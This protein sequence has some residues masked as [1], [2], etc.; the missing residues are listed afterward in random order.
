MSIKEKDLEKENIATDNGNTN[1]IQTSSAEFIPVK[2]KNFKS[3][4][5]IF[6]LLAIIILIIIIVVLLILAGY[7]LFN[8]NIISG[9]S[10]KGHDVSNLSKS[11][12]KYQL[13]NYIAENMPQEIKLQHG[14]QHIILVEKVIFYKIIFIFYLQCLVKLILNLDFL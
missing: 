4:F 7:T 13:D 3:S 8:N 10:I 1:L 11:D 6:K 12:A 9:V 5:S 14:D 2:N